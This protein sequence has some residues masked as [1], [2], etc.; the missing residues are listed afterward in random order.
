MKF[1]LVFLLVIYKPSFCQN[2]LDTIY[3]F[4]FYQQRPDLDGSGK[5]GS[6]SLLLFINDTIKVTLRGKESKVATKEF[7]VNATMEGI[8]IIKPSN[9]IL[10]VNIQA[11][12]THNEFWLGK[13]TFKLDTTIFI[14]TNTITPTYYVPNY[15][16]H[17][18]R[19][20]PSIPLSFF[21]TNSNSRF[22]IM[23]NRPRVRKRLKA[24][25]DEACTYTYNTI[26][27]ELSKNR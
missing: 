22:H 10:K 12:A 1:L 23:L 19:L 21:Y 7:A 9:Q 20:G 4:D 5:I 26:A 17:S 13:R 3:L 18:M 2:I 14:I 6:D 25:L 24:K 27:N 8:R 16:W 15:K 11:I